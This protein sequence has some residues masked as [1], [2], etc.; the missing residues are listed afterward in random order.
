MVTIQEYEKLCIVGLEATQEVRGTERGGIV[1][2][3]DFY[4]PC[5]TNVGILKVPAVNYKT[6]FDNTVEL[7]RMYINSMAREG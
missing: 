6:A 7:D 2:Q 5:S 3:G 1:F 4:F